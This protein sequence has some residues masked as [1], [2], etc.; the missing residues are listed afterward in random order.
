MPSRV[1]KILQHSCSMNRTAWIRRGLVD[2]YPTQCYVHEC[3]V[4]GQKG[5]G[6][7]NDRRFEYGQKCGP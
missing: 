5:D 3:E 2:I 6:R 1:G 4:S 7:D